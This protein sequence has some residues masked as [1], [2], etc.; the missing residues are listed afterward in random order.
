MHQA[1]KNSYTR[2]VFCNTLSSSREASIF[3]CA[4]KA[5]DGN[6]WVAP[7]DGTRDGGPDV[8]SG[9]IIS[10]EQTPAGKSEMA[11]RAS[12]NQVPKLLSIV[13]TRKC[14]VGYG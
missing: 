14:F 1:I 13:R 3:R 11:L 2:E 9:P 4:L 10:K 5:M 8:V 6:K 7:V 12:R